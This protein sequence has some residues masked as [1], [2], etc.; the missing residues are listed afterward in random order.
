MATASKGSSEGK[1]RGRGGRGKGEGKGRGGLKQYE[2]SRSDKELDLSKLSEQDLKKLIDAEEAEE[3]SLRAEEVKLIKDLEAAKLESQRARWRESQARDAVDDA[4]RRASHKVEYL[5]CEMA[6]LMQTIETRKREKVESQQTELASQAEL[7]SMVLTQADAMAKRDKLAV[8][9]AK[10]EE[11]AR[12]DEA[13]AAQIEAKIKVIEAKVKKDKGKVDVVMA[14]MD[15]LRRESEEA[16]RVRRRLQEEWDQ[17][18]KPID[19]V[20]NA[21]IK[22]WQYGV[23]SLLVL[24]ILVMF[25]KLFFSSR[26]KPELTEY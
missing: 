15:A 21:D 3:A 24:I 10:L 11:Q 19:D 12:A 6:E 5:T 8:E 7:D 14:E 9:V 26:S 13:A 17:A 2:A 23:Y 18:K 16:Q 25:F 4:R 20:E 1:G 22:L